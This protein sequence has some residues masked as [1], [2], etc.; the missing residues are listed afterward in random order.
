MTAPRPSTVAPLLGAALLLVAGAG[1]GP[2]GPDAAGP[3]A[4]TSGADVGGPDAATIDPL[5]AA[6]VSVRADGCGPR[7]RFGVGTVVGERAIV[8]VAHVI[9]GS[10]AVTVVG[11]DGA[12]VAAEVVYFDPADDV[13]VLRP[14]Q[15]VGTPTALSP[16]EPRPGAP[17]T[18]LL[19]RLGAAP[20]DVGTLDVRV[21]RAVTIRTTD[22]Y[23]E[24]ELDRSG[25]EMAAEIEPGDSGA[26]VHTADGN[27]GMVWARS[28]ERPGRAWTVDLPDV[29][30]D[31][32]GLPRLVEPV[33]V[34]RCVDGP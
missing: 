18:L 20:G 32:A 15:P 23:R 31:P 7:T 29:V 33:D 2:D 14:E 28:S 27:A 3:P 17:G 8:T 24:S 19:P 25:A 26:V 30:V 13:A 16:S 4:L 1:C 34:Q 21:V 12:D 10:G 5:G 6:T 9:A 22:I 11:E